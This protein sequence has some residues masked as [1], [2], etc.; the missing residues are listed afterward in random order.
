MP[1]T[2]FNEVGWLFP[3]SSSAN[4]ECDSYVKFN[5]TEP[6]RPWDYGTLA[7]SAWMDQTVLGNPIAATPTGII[8]QQETTND[9][10]G[11]P[12]TSTFSTGYFFIAEGEEWAFVDMIIPD[13]KWGT[14]AGSQNAQVQI[15]FNVT[16][17]PGDTPVVYGPYVM[18]STTEYIPVR[19]RG[20]QMSITITSSDLGSFWRIGRIRYR[21]APAGRN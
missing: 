21:W 20:R 4:G 12:I 5:V 3:S 13:M 7:R 14:Y 11:Q 1:N 15:S 2:P 18:T 8:Y 10:D 6:G 16:N 9:N 19:F 17:Y